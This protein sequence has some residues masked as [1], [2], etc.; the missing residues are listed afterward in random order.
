MKKKLGLLL[1]VLTVLLTLV[2]CG[3]NEENAEFQVAGDKK[4]W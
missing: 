2:A 3:K 4:K 1:L